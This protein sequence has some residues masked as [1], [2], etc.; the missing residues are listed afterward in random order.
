MY[1]RYIDIKTI[2]RGNFIS[3]RLEIHLE[4]VK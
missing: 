4:S 2:E 1:S 3:V